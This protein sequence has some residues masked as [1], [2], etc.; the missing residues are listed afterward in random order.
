MDPFWITSLIR[1]LTSS[2]LVSLFLTVMPSM[3]DRSN[4]TPK[5][6]KAILGGLS[7]FCLSFHLFILL[8]CLMR[9]FYAVCL[10]AIICWVMLVCVLYNSYVFFSVSVVMLAM[11]N[12][13]SYR[14]VL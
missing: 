12:V 13:G 9:I 1:V 6:S 3:S 11:F 5:Q 4:V 10:V 8:L 14:V 7:V 2:I